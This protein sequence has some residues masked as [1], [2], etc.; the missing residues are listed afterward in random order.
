MV[1]SVKTTVFVAVGKWFSVVEVLTVPGR[2]RPVALLESSPVALETGLPAVQGAVGA[3]PV[4]PG[5]GIRNS[6]GTSILTWGG[7]APKGKRGMIAGR[8]ALQSCF[9]KGPQEPCL[10]GIMLGGGS[11]ISM[12]T[13]IP[14]IID[15]TH[16]KGGKSG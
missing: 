7:G 12:V 2:V 10:I 5:G 11:E 4:P 15:S 1:R 3:A 13:E 8:F 6:R 16:M 9:W 14:D